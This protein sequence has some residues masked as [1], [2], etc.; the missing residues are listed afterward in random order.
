MIP[1]HLRL[2]SKCSRTSELWH[3]CDECKYTLCQYCGVRHCVK[4]NLPSKSE[5]EKIM[6]KENKMESSVGKLLQNTGYCCVCLKATSSITK[7]KTGGTFCYDCVEKILFSWPL[8][9]DPKLVIG[10]EI[11]PNQ[12]K[13]KRA[14]KDGLACGMSLAKAVK[15]SGGSID[16]YENWAKMTLEDFISEVM[17]PN[18]VHFVFASKEG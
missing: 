15:D 2:C 4:K 9:E 8:P 7:S 16:S 10:K 18:G 5:V 17:A 13:L 6:E 1:D 14:R 11:E 3:N 12:E